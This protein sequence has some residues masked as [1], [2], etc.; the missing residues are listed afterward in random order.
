[1]Q[2][3]IRKV[4]NARSSINLTFPSSCRRLP[5][6]ISRPWLGLFGPA[7]MPPYIVNI[8]SRTTARYT[9]LAIGVAGIPSPLDLLCSRVRSRGRARRLTAPD[10]TADGRAT[11][12]AGG[13]RKFFT[14]TGR[15]SLP[16][17]PATSASDQL[18]VMKLYWLLPKQRAARA[19]CGE[20]VGAVLGPNPRHELLEA[21]CRPS[22]PR[23]GRVQ[24]VLRSTACLSVL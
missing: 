17:M 8:C 9:R 1:M 15:R 19:S 5:D 7:G 21:R 14:A 10:V 12:S 11:S 23:H 22:A 4:K 6:R 2:K 18:K 3:V 13:S 24:G 16:P 20:A